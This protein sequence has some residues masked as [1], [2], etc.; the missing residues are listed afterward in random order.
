MNSLTKISISAFLAACCFIFFATSCQ[1]ESDIPTPKGKQQEIFKKDYVFNIQKAEY[2]VTLETNVE[3]LSL[4]FDEDAVKA[5]LQSTEEF[6]SDNYSL[7]E[8]V[9]ETVEETPNDPDKFINVIISP[10]QQVEGKV[11]TITLGD[12]IADLIE[13][14]KITSNWMFPANVSG[15]MKVT[16]G[17]INDTGIEFVNRRGRTLI[18]D[19]IVRL[20]GGGSYTFRATVERGETNRYRSCQVGRGCRFIRWSAIEGAAERATVFTSNC[21]T[22][23]GC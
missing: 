2:S 1:D 18:A 10:I 13:E 17:N 11:I 22:P 8:P 7:L 20:S 23:P 5:I 12:N 6:N 15:K 3:E 16:S 21:N 9:S 14:N 19:L 4:S